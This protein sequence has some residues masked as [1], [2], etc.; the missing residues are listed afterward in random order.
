MLILLVNHLQNNI[1]VLK[2]MR[3]TPATPLIR[4]VVHPNK[5]EIAIATVL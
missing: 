4:I 5:E 1:K 3:R 2:D